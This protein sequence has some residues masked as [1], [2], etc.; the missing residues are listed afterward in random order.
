MIK[1]NELEIVLR[2]NKADGCYFYYIVNLLE[3][4]K[5]WR[6]KIFDLGLL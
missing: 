3:E 5:T 6:K 1:L 2:V 4:Y